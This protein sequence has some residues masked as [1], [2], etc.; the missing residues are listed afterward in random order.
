MNVFIFRLNDDK[1]IFKENKSWLRREYMEGYMTTREA[2][3]KWK[4]C[5][6]QVQNLCRN[7]SIEGV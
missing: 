2:A 1:T 5:V 7:N 4:I 6:R 3:E